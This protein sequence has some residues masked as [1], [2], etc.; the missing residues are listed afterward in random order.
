MQGGRGRDIASLYLF[1]SRRAF[2]ETIPP[3]D[4]VV[5]SEGSE[6]ADGSTGGGYVGYQVGHQIFRGC[7]SLGPN[8]EVFDAEVEAALAGANKAASAFHMT[9]FASDL[10]ICLDN[11]EVATRLLSLSTR[12]SQ[13][14]FSSFCSVATAWPLRERLPHTYPGAIRVRWV[15]GHTD[16]PGNEVADTAAK[17]GASLPPPPLLE[18]SY[19]SLK[20]RCKASADSAARTLWQ[21]VCPQTY[22]DLEIT[23]APRLPDELR[24]P[25][26][27]LG[28]ILA[29]R[30]GHGAFAD[31]HERFQNDKSISTWL[32]PSLNSPKETLS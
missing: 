22:R 30:T 12:S 16:V 1:N 4:V 27:L 9:R 17:E 32:S 13:A 31:Y 21:S 25:R 8:K 23:T 11:L 24:L 6:L 2:Y 7:F 5:F 15:P 26:P 18:H 19:A 3:L 29:A 20:R 14:A 28:R 10:W